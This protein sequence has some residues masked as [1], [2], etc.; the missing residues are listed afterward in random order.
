MGTETRASTTDVV[1]RIKR[2]QSEPYRFGFFSSLRYLECLYPDLP[3]LGQAAKPADE[4]LRLGQE[5]SL[6]FAPSTLA[7]FRAGSRSR[8][9]LL[10]CFFFGLFGPHGPL[11]L[12][13]TEYA[14]ERELSSHDPTFRRF[15]DI[16]HHRMLALFYRAWADAQPTVSLDRREDRRFDIYAGSLIGTADSSLRNRD[17]ISDECKFFWAGRLSLAARPAEALP[18]ILQDYFR[19]PFS[20]REFVGEWLPLAERDWLRLGINKDS[21]SL[22]VNTML[23]DSVWSCQHRFQVTCGPIAYDAFQALL[24]GGLGLR[25]LRDLIRNYLGDEFD[26]NCRLILESDEIPALLLGNS[27]QLGWTTWLGERTG[28]GDAHDVIVAPESPEPN[29]TTLASDLAA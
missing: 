17:E 23:G 14:R 28:K 6:A 12:H 24:P 8:T 19:L 16:F 3:R 18:A 25:R 13:L 26:W 4:A 27:G 2:M 22:G 5:P 29:G 21:C 1:E 7:S 15:A 10:A 20:L 11:P 9:H